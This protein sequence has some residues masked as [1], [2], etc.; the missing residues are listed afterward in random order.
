MI[1]SLLLGVLLSVADKPLSDDLYFIYDFDTL[2]RVNGTAYPIQLD[3]RWFTDGKFGKGY[4]YRKS[5]KNLYPAEIASATRSANGRLSIKEQPFKNSNSQYWKGTYFDDVIISAYVKGKA[6]DELTVE[7]A[8]TAFTGDEKKVQEK[9]LKILQKRKP[10]AT[11][12]DVVFV[13]DESF[14]QKVKLTGD[15]Q[16]VAAYVRMD[17]RLGGRKAAFHLVSKN[18]LSFDAKKFQLEIGREKTAS[19][20][21]FLPG[22]VSYSSREIPIQ[23]AAL[24]KAF[25]ANEGSF[26][27]WVK[28][29]EVSNL[30]HFTGPF[31]HIAPQC[32]LRRE[33]FRIGNRSIDNP[34]DPT[35]AAWQHITFTWD[36]ETIASYRNGKLI[37]Q[38]KSLPKPIE[39][40]EKSKM[41]LGYK[42]GEAAN[43]ILDEVAIFSRALTAAE[44][45]SLSR[46]TEP[47]L[48]NAAEY[49]AT[50]FSSLMFFR[51]EN[52]ARLVFSVSAPKEE[53]LTAKLTIGGITFPETKLDVRKEMTRVIVPFSAYL[54]N[55]GKHPMAFSL[56]TA[57]GKVCFTSSKT[58]EILPRFDKDAFKV[59]SWGGSKVIA[60]EYLKVMGINAIH[61]P[62]TT[63]D[64]QVD[65]LSR[66]GFHLSP[67]LKNYGQFKA[68]GYDKQ[69]IAAGVET[70]M[71]VFSGRGNWTMTLCNSEVY[72]TRYVDSSKDIVRWRELAR[73]ELGHEPVF[74]ITAEA[75][76]IKRPKGWTG[77]KDGVLDM[78]N[79][80]RTWLWLTTR[81]QGPHLVNEINHEVIHRLSPG[82][83]TWSEPNIPYSVDMSADWHYEY[84]LGKILFDLKRCTAYARQYGKPYMPTLS[85]YYWPQHWGKGEA[86]DPENKEKKKEVT[87]DL[88]QTLDQ[89]K[90]KTLLSLGGTE[91]EALSLFAIDAWVEGEQCEKF[92]ATARNH[93]Y[94]GDP[95][96]AK[97]YGEAMRATYYPLATLLHRVPV[98]KNAKVAVFLPLTG[99]A[100]AHW[101]WYYQNFI[102]RFKPMLA[103]VWQDF[104]VIG[105]EITAEKLKQYK[106]IFC[107]A[108]RYIMRKNYDLLTESAKNGAVIYVDKECKQT[109]PGMKRY[110]DPFAPKEIWNALKKTAEKIRAELKDEADIYAEGEK[111]I[112][113]TFR[114]G[115]E[116][117]TPYFV[118]IN[119]AEKTGPMNRFNSYPKWSKPYYK[120]YGDEQ[121]VTISLKVPNKSVIYDFVTSRQVPYKY[122]K[123]R[124]VIRTKMGAAEGMLLCVY[125][126]ALKSLKMKAVNMKPGAIGT[127]GVA[128]RDEDGKW[129]RGYQLIKLEATDANG[130]KRDE[131]G[132]YRLTDGKA[133]IPFYFSQNE[134]PQTLQIKVTEKTSGLT[135]TAT[136]KVK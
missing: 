99:M 74:D 22:G 60:P 55:V 15:W 126:R 98:S 129:P 33:F 68:T 114:R 92:L 70:V 130:K 4:Y 1:A 105:D 85:M 63:M 82:N 78:D 136:I 81:G 18:K 83:I 120:P 10:T 115:E 75:L 43:L 48:Q 89:I 11:L 53:I 26:S 87:V 128:L 77:P 23:G 79:E 13:K 95:D 9:W 101:W 6:G 42:G 64:A 51:T 131:S 104:D 31:F 49:L 61:I 35:D 32:D 46:R 66:H 29:P 72:T 14:P 8:V 59:L 34:I 116:G 96:M 56:V 5:G 102:D 41:L 109:Y 122:E 119:G 45:A 50:P 52:P 67:N 20:T 133:K 69:K 7:V 93:Y 73:K 3:D 88:T 94:V 123:G 113:Y 106:Y 118:V 65:D 44:I 27:F 47:L 107:P 76:D 57:D 12:D 108:S 30:P 2:M 17:S 134:Q 40:I 110:D 80:T 25:S 24:M 132:W 84:R 90:L 19:P 117:S 103:D 28:Y 97:P 21:A 16:R 100:N 86:V 91:A 58:V 38:H 124:A 111:G 135:Q 36:A 127:L 62:A 37:K 71:D 125:P 121:N 112:V 39:G 54:L